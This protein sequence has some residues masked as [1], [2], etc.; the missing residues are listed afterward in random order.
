MAILK[1]L[2]LENL[3]NITLKSLVIKKNHRINLNFLPS[4]DGTL[5]QAV[6]LNIILV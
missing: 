1:N 4:I 3:F 6:E 5:K 2:Y